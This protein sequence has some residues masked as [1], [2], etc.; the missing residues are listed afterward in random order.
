MPKEN[1][2]T[3]DMEIICLNCNKQKHFENAAYC[4]NCGTKLIFRK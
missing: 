3:E 2:K 4:S 1:K